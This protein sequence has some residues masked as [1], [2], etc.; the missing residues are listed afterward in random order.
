MALG[1]IEPQK[2]SFMALLCAYVTELRHYSKKVNEQDKENDKLG[3]GEC[4]QIA[5][6]PTVPWTLTYLK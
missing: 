4:Q 3:L 6:L 1:E 2:I 5:M